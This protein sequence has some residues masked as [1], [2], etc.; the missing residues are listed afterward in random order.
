MPAI[1]VKNI[2]HELYEQ[3]KVAAQAHYRSI[4]SEIISCLERTLLPTPILPEDRIQKARDLRATIGSGK[5]AAKDIARAI[6]RGR[7]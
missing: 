7:A 1:T 2:K 4:N 3:L 5:I 6:K